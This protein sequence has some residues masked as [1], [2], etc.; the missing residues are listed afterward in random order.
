[1]DREKIIEWVM[2]AGLLLMMVMALLPLVL[3]EP[4]ENTLTWLRWAYAAGAAVVL[5]TRLLQR[6]KGKNL[7][8]KRLYRINVVSAVLYCVSAAMPFYSRGTTDWV[9][10]L[11]AGAVLQMYASYM[12]ERELKKESL[13]K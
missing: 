12:I 4:S 7:R 2:A 8:I 1:M 5:V 6:Y 9:A 13:H 10:F 11:L 3:A